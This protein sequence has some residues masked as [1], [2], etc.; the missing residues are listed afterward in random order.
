MT[1]IAKEAP[2][3][4]RQLMYFV[5]AAESGSISAAA[6]VLEVSQ[7]AVSKQIDR[8][9]QDLGTIL[10]Q[11]DYAGVHL[12]PAGCALL[13]R[14]K[15]ILTQLDATK[16]HLSAFRNTQE[17]SVRLG[18]TSP[19][20]HVLVTPTVQGALQK[21]PRIKLVIKDGTS[22]ELRRWLE[23]GELDVAVSNR[24]GEWSPLIT[25]PIAV[26]EFYLIGPRE[27][28]K[29]DPKPIRFKDLSEYP[30]MQGGFATSLL[31]QEA[32]EKIAALRNVR[33]SF[34]FGSPINM[35]KDIMRALGRC[36][37]T[38]Y[39][40]FE[41]EI[42]SGELAARP[43]RQPRLT[44]TLYLARRKASASPDDQSEICDLV[45]AITNN[46]IRLGRYKWRNPNWTPK[47]DF[48]EL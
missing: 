13:E 29:D 5:R 30:L 33:L 10:L 20:S 6:A 3:F 37:V 48:V 27:K 38:F 12:T 11:R 42:L 35:R 43:I 8:L 32:I 17:R 19:A 22:E 23:A 31:R 14:A 24:T 28:V 16:N 26:Q 15:A 7:P 9:E 46:V 21:F 44:Q 36:T 47:D 39:S 1:A 25:E 41:Q 40:L 18:V 45:K 4:L 2:N 34:D